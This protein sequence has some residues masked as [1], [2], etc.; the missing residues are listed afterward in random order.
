[1]FYV[2]E[3]KLRFFLFFSIRKFIY[4]DTINNSETEMRIKGTD[5]AGVDPPLL[6]NSRSG[7]LLILK[8]SVSV[9]HPL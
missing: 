2:T 8:G 5:V 9:Y 7:I 3:T 6:I 1:M 4:L